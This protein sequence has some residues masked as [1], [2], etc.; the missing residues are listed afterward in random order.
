MEKHKAILVEKNG[1]Q[2]KYKL[3]D[4]KHSSATTKQT[5][6]AVEDSDKSI[7]VIT[8]SSKS[9]KPYSKK[10]PGKL[11]SF[12]PLVAAVISALVIGSVLGFFLLRLF[13]DVEGQVIG[14]PTGQAT[15][16]TVAETAAGAAETAAV[17]LDSLQAYVLQAGIFSKEENAVKWAEGYLD[18]GVPTMVWE[19]D[20]QFFLLAGIAET[21]E[22][23]AQMAENLQ[24]N[25]SIDI[26]VKEWSTSSGEAKLTEEEKGW[27]G[28][29]QN[30]WT[31]SLASWSEKQTLSEET[32]N[33]LA[34]A[35]PKNTETLTPL[36][37]AV[38]ES[39][40]QATKLLQLMYNYEKTI[41]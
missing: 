4:K 13:V 22:Q 6:A 11:K 17:Q 15:P 20:N 18:K 41:Q 33:E 8:G 12:K 36:L 37:S 19:K 35:A 10:R 40:E 3:H 1:E 14:E 30:A 27:I 9:K 34:E 31:T 5:A 38:N 24:E 21:K 7:P 28:E 23:A 32:L 26:Y 39:D 29:F 25:G 16:A 2:L